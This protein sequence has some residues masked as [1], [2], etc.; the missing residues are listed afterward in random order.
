[1]T[2]FSATGLAC[3]RGARLVFRDIGFALAAGD[4]LALTGPNGAGK[5]SL[6]RLAA[7][8]LAPL[9]GALAWQGEAV[10]PGNPAHGARLHY[11]GHEGAVKPGLT[12]AEHLR[13]WA[14]LSGGRVDTPGCDALLKIFA[15]DGAGGLLAKTLSA[16][17]KRRLSLT[18]L[19][20]ARRPLWLLDE[21]ASALDGAAISAL[22]AATERHR[23]QGGI[24]IAAGHGALPWQSTHTINLGGPQ[25]AIGGAA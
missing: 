21:P 25:A 18:R 6:L 3:R 20:L 19:L 1:M 12:C 2:Q 4:A 9:R 16:G 17:Q 22:Q 15:L 14:A 13:Y 11:I 5:S 7:G 24:V 8:L 23:A 10:M